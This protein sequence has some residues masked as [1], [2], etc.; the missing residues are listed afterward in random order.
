[1]ASHVSNPGNVQDEAEEKLVSDNNTSGE[2][3]IEIKFLDSKNGDAKID[4]SEV[5]Q[6]FVGMGKEEL[7][8]FAND[9]FWVKMRWF[10][11]ILFWVLWIGM[12]AG[13]V[14]IILLAP[15]CNSIDS[16]EK[17]VNTVYNVNVKHFK[18][19]N[20]DGKGDIAGE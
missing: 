11:F 14:A 1:M 3:K 7:M 10:L 5:R 2:P 6:V 18:D 16:K 17:S 15:K 13:A 4:I 12:L 19:S 8:K 20:N 9:P